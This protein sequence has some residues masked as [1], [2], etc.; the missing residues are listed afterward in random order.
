MSQ[1]AAIRSNNIAGY[2]EDNSK[3]IV[4]IFLTSGGCC[5]LLA[6]TVMNTLKSYN[7]ED[8]DTLFNEYVWTCGDEDSATITFGDCPIYNNIHCQPNSVDPIEP[9]KPKKPRF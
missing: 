4:T 8:L 2:I 7:E 5:V 9:P 1:F 6:E 3:G